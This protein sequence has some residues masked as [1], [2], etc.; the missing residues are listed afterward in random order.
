[1]NDD[2]EAPPWLYGVVGLLLVLL[3]AW[4]MRRDIGKARKRARKRRAADNKAA[5]SVAA[6]VDTTEVAETEAMI[7][8]AESEVE[9][10][11]IAA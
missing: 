5:Q 4:A 1:M 10:E 7:T 2:Y 8:E 6:S 3:L 9:T 11:E